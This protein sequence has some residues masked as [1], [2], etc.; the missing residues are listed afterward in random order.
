[1]GRRNSRNI[2]RPPW[3]QEFGRVYW[4]GN[5]VFTDRGTVRGLDKERYK[6]QGYDSDDGSAQ[7]SDVERDNC[8]E[9]ALEIGRFNAEIEFF[10]ESMFAVPKRGFDYI[11]ADTV[12]KVF[13]AD[14]FWRA[15]LGVR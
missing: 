15:A 1:M 6:N 13:D 14:T 4:K 2:K 12:V 3:A 7:I 8:T 9:N 10:P 11:P 5:V